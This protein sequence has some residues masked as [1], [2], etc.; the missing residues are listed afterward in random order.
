MEDLGAPSSL[1]GEPVIKDEPLVKYERKQF[2][3][4]GAELV[5]DRRRNPFIFG[6]FSPEEEREIARKLSYGLSRGETCSRP[7]PSGSRLTY[8]EGWRATDIANSIF[9]FNGWRSQGN[10]VTLVEIY[11]LSSNCYLRS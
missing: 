10:K 4:C 3:E 9:G 1:N 5:G 6:A 2:C 8:I 7:G 11:R